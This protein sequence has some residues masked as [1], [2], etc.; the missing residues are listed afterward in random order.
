MVMTS[1]RVDM[2]SSDADPFC[3]SE[4]GEVEWCLTPGAAMAKSVPYTSDL[5]PD[6][7]PETPPQMVN[8]QIH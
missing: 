5:N 4:N 3:F 8:L 1:Y 7:D 2:T 6:V